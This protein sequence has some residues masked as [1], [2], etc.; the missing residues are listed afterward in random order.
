MMPST[1]DVITA[2]LS[3][4]N[5]RDLEAFLA[6]FDPDVEMHDLRSGAVSRGIDD[7]RARYSALFASSPALHSR[8]LHRSVLGDLVHD[9][10]LVT[11]RAGGDVEIL[12]TYEV[13]DGRIRRVWW[14]RAA[15]TGLHIV[16]AEPADLGIV[17]ELGASTY[18]EHFAAIWSPDGMARYLAGEFDRAAVATELG[19]ITTTYLLGLAPA[20]AGF[21]K[22]RLD[23]AVPDDGTGKGVELQKVYVRRAA[24][25][26][27]L[28]ARLLAAAIDVARAAGAALIWLD[29]LKTNPRARR[30]YERHGFRVTGELPFAT[31]L[32]EQ[33][34]WVMTRPTEKLVL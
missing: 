34:M 7:V 25:G 6:S 18:R 28:G 26:S 10:E 30:F 19:S 17:L 22:L 20:P 33:G 23:R 24:V 15:A 29:V 21:A 27:G 8:L 12:I 14:A 31:D 2:N 16:R 5:A 32:A 4:Y 13:R 1:R 3:A 9:H 11:G